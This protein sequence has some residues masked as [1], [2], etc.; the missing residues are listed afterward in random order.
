LGT[1]RRK[2][3]VFLTGAG[4]SAESGLKTFRDSDGLWENYAI[5]DVASIEAWHKNPQLVLDF[6]NMRRTQCVAA[7]PNQAHAIIASLEEQFDVRIITQNIDDLHERAESSNVLHLHGCINFSR[8][9]KDDSKLFPYTYDLHLG[10]CDENGNQLRPH[11]VWFGEAVPL[12]EKAYEIVHY[13]AEI[14]V[15]IGTSLQVYPAAGLTQQVP[16]EIP[17]YIIDPNMPVTSNRYI[18]INEKAAVG[19]HTLQ[20]LLKETYLTL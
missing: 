10:D 15:I 9:V 4:V 11:I 2:K 1:R 8:S 5:E 19:M 3:I 13:W 17:I 6:Y 14:I 16:S 12:I 20:Q 7:Q 18:P